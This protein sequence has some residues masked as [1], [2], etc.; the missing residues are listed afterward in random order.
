MN[1]HSI[2]LVPQSLIPVETLRISEVIL[3]GVHSSVED[4]LSSI[5][6]IL[7]PVGLIAGPLLVRVS[8]QDE[9]KKVFLHFALY[10]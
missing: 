10:R 5:A 7:R 2:T 9:G 6:T 8:S 4:Q 1:I 3:L